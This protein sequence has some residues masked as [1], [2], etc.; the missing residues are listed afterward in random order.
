M[1]PK[2]K[3][4]VTTL[5]KEAP[6]E[7][8]TSEIAAHGWDQ[9][10]LPLVS[11]SAG[12][13]RRFNVV[14]RCA[15]A[16]IYVEAHRRPIGVLLQ[17]DAHVRSTPVGPL[18]DNRVIP[19]RSFMRYKAFT[20][21]MG[22]SSHQTWWSA[23]DEWLASTHCDGYN[24]PRCLPFHIFSA[25]NQ[26]D[27]HDEGSRSEFERVHKRG[28]ARTDGDDLTWSAARPGARHGREPTTVA[29]NT[30]ID[31]FH[32]DVAVPSGRKRV[33]ATADTSWDVKNYVNVYPDG[34]ARIAKAGR[35]YQAWNREDSLVADRAQE[36]ARRQGGRKR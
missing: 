8:L 16:D 18:Q 1:T 9:G 12:S 34:M 36:P 35:A 23:F 13:G 25:K 26:L 3:V 19:L 20:S 30:L 22:M 17:T 27:L 2:P 6:P 31:G 7:R 5:G 29:G 15:A 24:D 21:H 11:L 33:V 10:T 4:V 14:P 28:F 32:W